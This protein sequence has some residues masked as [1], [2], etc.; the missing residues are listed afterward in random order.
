MRVRPFVATALLAIGP[1]ITNA[2][3][4][5]GSDGSQKV[6][7]FASDAAKEEAP[8]SS[9]LAS[10]VAAISQ[11]AQSPASCAACE[12][13]ILQLKLVAARGDD[14]FINVMTELCKRSGIQDHDV[15]EG[16]IAL[17][18]P[19]VAHGLRGM[20]V[21]SRTSRLACVAFMGL[22]SHPEVK[23]HNVTFPSPKPKATRP[24]PSGL[25]PLHIVHYSDIHV[26]PLYTVGANANCSKPI[27]CREYD[28]GDK[29]GNNNFP[30]GL[31]GEH[32]CDAPISLEESMYAAIKEI[33]PDAA[34]SIFTGDIVDHAVWDTSE[35]QNTLSVEDAYGRMSRAGMLVYGTAG[36]HE[37]SPANSF[38]PTAAN[39]TDAQWLYD[40]LSSTWS[41]WVGQKAA[42][43]T[44][45]EF[46][47]YSVQH[48]GSANHAQLRVISLSTNLYYT[49]N[50]WLYEEPMETDPS[51]QL[52]WLV[53]ELDAAEKAGERVYI[54]GHMPMG[55]HDAFHDASN[56]F[57]QIVN[58]YSAA[59]AAMFFGHTHF[60]EFELS[61]SNY[62]NR[63]HTNAVAMSYI[64]PSMTPMSG[65]PA[66]RVYTVDPIT[67]GVLD[68]VTYIAN[69][70]D[71]SFNSAEGPKWT[72]YYSAKETYG[73]LITKGEA[74]EEDELA[75]AFWH[76]V[77]EVLEKDASAFEEFFA[78]RKRGWAAGSCEGECKSTEICKLR[79]ARAQDN[80]VPPGL[81]F[82]LLRE[83]KESGVRVERD[84]C[85]GSVV[86]DTLGSLV[87]D[88][89]ML[90]AFEKM[91]VDIK[92]FDT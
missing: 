34:F 37:A 39:S 57:D 29:P 4:G 70:S 88:S 25:K 83:S 26:D 78:R 51:G 69:M 56:Y 16:S 89:E 80:C 84:E 30:A 81:R 48:P 23:L 71:P 63:S 5:P 2:F 62:G 75:P 1:G 53:S 91:V 19:I 27:C 15:C 9:M 20:A 38:P 35:S 58:R 72:K 24:S 43:T 18:G 85:E 11:D 50:Y 14:F 79:A 44:V 67:F 68:A 59:I 76:S 87:V 28:E 46:G 73:P 31:H 86:R 12:G 65:H 41:Q 33:A 52:A 40:L 13:L 54:I 3:L 32:T 21:G 49:H 42:A 61:Y 64:A 36:N 92:S 17:E 47:A 82:G 55:S 90:A 8:N 22:C 10:L 6:L 60:D 74:A 77:T 7:S 66:F 45:K